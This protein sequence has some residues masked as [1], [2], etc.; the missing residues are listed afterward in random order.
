VAEWHGAADE[1]EVD[2]TLTPPAMR[3]YAVII[4]TSIAAGA[5]ALLGS[6]LGNAAG[7][8]GLMAGAVIGGLV[9]AVAGVQVVV[10]LAWLSSAESRGGMLGGAIGFLV[11]AAIAVTNLDTP[12]A[13]VLSCVL[14]GAGVLLGAGATRAR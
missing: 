7:Q 3:P 6:I 12:V 2:R 5:G 9:G 13:P 10:R 11:A 1:Y 4:V 14:V 8:R